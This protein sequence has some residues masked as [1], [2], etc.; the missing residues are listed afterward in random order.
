[1]RV[2]TSS[3]PIASGGKTPRPA[4]FDHRRAAHARIGALGRD[5]DVARADKRGVAGKAAPGDDSDQRRRSRQPREGAERRHVEPGDDRNIGVAR[6][7]AAALG[8]DDDRQTPLVGK[9]QDPVRLLVAE[10]AL[11]ARKNGEVVSQHRSPRRLRAEQGGVHR[12]DSGDDAVRR[13]FGDEVGDVAAAPLGSDGERAIFDEAA[14]VAEVV[15]VFA[16][17][18]LA[19]RPAPRH[20]VGP[21]R[22]EAFCMAGDDFGEIRSD[23]VEIDCPGLLFDRF[24]VRG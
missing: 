14:L 3:G 6:A 8:E 4:A 13:R 11:R 18:A 10:I 23:F 1:M 2:C 5:D 9:T 17:G 22:V 21:L 19:A 24:R 15:N 16:G 20:R 7:T 12:A